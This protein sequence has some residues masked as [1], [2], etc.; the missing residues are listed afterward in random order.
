LASFSSNTTSYFTTCKE[1]SYVSTSLCA[2]VE[3]FIIFTRINYL[4]SYFTGSA[5]RFSET[6][7]AFAW[8]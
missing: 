3:D 2:F 5:G 6:V 7:V 8:C 4:V 1:C